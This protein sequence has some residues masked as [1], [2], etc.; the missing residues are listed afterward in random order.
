MNY[1]GFS[2]FRSKFW[3]CVH[4]VLRLTKLL[5]WSLECFSWSKTLQNPLQIPSN[6]WKKPIFGRKIRQ[7]NVIF[8]G[9]S[10]S[11]FENLFSFFQLFVYN[12]SKNPMQSSGKF[13]SIKSCL[14]LWLWTYSRLWQKYLQLL[15]W[16]DHSFLHNL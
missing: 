5:L 15:Q 4:F 11:I 9:G 3:T 1:I 8:T 7:I 12:F 14:I 2:M 6:Q 10:F 13:K 16:Q